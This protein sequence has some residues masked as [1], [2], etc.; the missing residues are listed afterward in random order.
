MKFIQLWKIYVDLHRYIMVVQGE[1]VAPPKKIRPGREKQH[2]H[3]E[4]LEEQKAEQWKSEA[5][6][7]KMKIHGLGDREIWLAQKDTLGDY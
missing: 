2:T 4:M 3:E 6:K 7:K 1:N 5:K